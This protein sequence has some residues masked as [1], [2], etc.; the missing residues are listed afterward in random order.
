MKGLTRSLRRSIRA[1]AAP[2][3]LPYKVRGLTI[4]VADPGG[5]NAFFTGVLG[6]LPEGNILLLGAIGYFTLTRGDTDITATFTGNIAVGSAATADATLNG[7]EVDILPSTA[8][9]AGVSGV[10]SANRLANA[11][12]VMLN[13]TD[14]SLEL[15][16]NGFIADAAIAAASSLLV[17]ADMSLLIAKMMDD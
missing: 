5:A 4:D 16:L 6:D 3:I 8:L 14:G 11:T 2:L 15:N 10:S 12:A 13:N 9:A 7:S 17:S 1:P